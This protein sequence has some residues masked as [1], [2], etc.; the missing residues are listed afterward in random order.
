MK[1][2]SAPL[3]LEGGGAGGEGERVDKTNLAGTSTV[4][5]S[6]ALSFQG[7]GNNALLNLHE[8]GN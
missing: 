5:L 8:F 4:P 1:L 3:P 6:L 2:G 7:R